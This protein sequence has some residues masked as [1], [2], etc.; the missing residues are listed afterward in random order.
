MIGMAFLATPIPVEAGSRKSKL[1]F[2]EAAFKSL[3]KKKFYLGKLSAKDQIDY[4]RG[5]AGVKTLADVIN[6]YW[7]N[8]KEIHEQVKQGRISYGG[9]GVE[10][11]HTDYT[12]HFG[13]LQK[14]PDIIEIKETWRSKRR[15]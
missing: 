5:H 10:N 11:R 3:L 12:V 15:K 1:A 14:N 6:Y 2:S 7:K 8:L 9:F 4:L 13:I